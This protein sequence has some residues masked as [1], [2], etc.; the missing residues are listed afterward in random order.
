[1]WYD[2]ETLVYNIDS[3]FLNFTKASFVVKYLF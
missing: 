3:I 2:L 1:M